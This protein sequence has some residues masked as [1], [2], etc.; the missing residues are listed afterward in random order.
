MNARLQAFLTPLGAMVCA[1]AF[2][3]CAQYLKT[4]PRQTVDVEMQVALPLFVQVFMAGGDRYLAAN[5]AAIRALVVSTDKMKAEDYSILAKV[6]EDVSWLNP[7]HEDNYYIA[8]AILPWVGQLDAAQAIL[9]RAS[10]VRPYDFQ[11]AFYYAFHLL[12]FKGDAEAASAGLRAAAEKLPEGDERVQLQNIAA[13]WLDHAKDL[14]MSIRVVEAMAQQA[15]R[16]DF[17]AYLERRVVRLKNHKTLRAAA[18]AFAARTGRHPAEPEDLVR[19]GLIP[20]LPA[21]PFGFGFTVGKAGQI[22]LRNAP[23]HLQKP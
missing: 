13:M 9:L 17:R 18:E 15:K 21:D 3:A 8:A 16:R 2:L 12:H 7:A 5:V 19:A 22:V 23:P 1:A 20:A 14:E 10:G 4:A 6:Q 11:P